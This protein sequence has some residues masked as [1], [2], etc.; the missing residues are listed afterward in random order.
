MILRRPPPAPE[1]PRPFLDAYLRLLAP[2]PVP[3]LLLPLPSR[4]P[5]PRPRPADD[6]LPYLRG[7]H[8]LLPATRVQL[9]LQQTGRAGQRQR[10]LPPAAVLWLVIGMGLLAQPSVPNTW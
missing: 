8:R 6:P 1:F 4:R 2:P 7:L 5:P 3:L 9:I 10:R